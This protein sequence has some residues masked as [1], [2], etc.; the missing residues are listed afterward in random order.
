M[1]NF[2]ISKRTDFARRMFLGHMQ[3]P[4]EFHLN[5]NSAM[6]LRDFYSVDHV[7]QNMLMPFFG[8]VTEVIVISFLLGFLFYTNIYIAYFNNLSNLYI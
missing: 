5:S 4:F 1:Q 7:F 8:L 2:L 3:K 6:I